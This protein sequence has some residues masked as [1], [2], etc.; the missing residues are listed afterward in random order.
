MS[1]P[2][3]VSVLIS[4]GRHPVSGVPRACRGDAVAMALGH[5]LAG[6]ALRI[7]HAGEANEPSL[8]DYMAYG[9]D[10]IEVLNIS[11]GEDG[12]SALASAVGNADI[13]LTGGRAE[14]G[15]G[16]GLLPYHL[17]QMLQRPVIGN[18]LEIEVEEGPSGR[19]A[20]L[21]QFLP[22]GQ[23]RRIACPLPLV[24]AVH[25]FAP[26]R[27]RYA[28]ARQIDGQITPVLSAVQSDGATQLSWAVENVSRR[29]IRLKA[30]DKKAGHA[31]LLSAIV[32][33]AKG[34]AVAFEGT[35]VDKAQVVLNYLR[36]HR[37]VDF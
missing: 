2:F 3:S 15:A 11:A 17:A 36:E 27:L 24:I 1:A 21:R 37:L 34:G 12:A 32:S 5:S 9:A 6:D 28:Y 4:A 16:S 29:P 22:K 25:P 18:V 35:T 31:R 8:K 19:E 13:I 10:K 14:Q 23:R 7:V 20:R 33:E 30:Q 26:A